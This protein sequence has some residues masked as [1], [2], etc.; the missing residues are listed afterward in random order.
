MH[1]PQC[2]YTSILNEI[3]SHPYIVVGMDAPSECATIMRKGDAQREPQ[4]IN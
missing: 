2:A 4:T 1:Y 3:N